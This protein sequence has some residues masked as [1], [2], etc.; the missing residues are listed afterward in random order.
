MPAN[1]LESCCFFKKQKKTDKLNTRGQKCSSACLCETDE[2]RLPRWRRSHPPPP[3][4]PSS[5]VSHDEF[6]ER[7]VGRVWLRPDHPLGPL[8]SQARAPLRYRQLMKPHPSSSEGGKK[9]GER[10]REGGRNEAKTAVKKQMESR[11]AF[12]EDG[13][14]GGG[15]VAYD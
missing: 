11:E 5:L 15:G 4:N 7:L 12:T 6:N 8:A 10:R 9:G 3:P 14:R 1:T 13:R 2:Q